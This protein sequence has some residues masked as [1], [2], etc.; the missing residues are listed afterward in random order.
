MAPQ[1]HSLRLRL[2]R[3]QG[4]ASMKHPLPSD[5]EFPKAATVR[6]LCRHKRWLSHTTNADPTRPEYPPVAVPALVH[7]AGTAPS[8]LATTAGRCASHVCTPRAVFGPPKLQHQPHP[9]LNAA[10]YAP[11]GLHAL[12]TYVPCLIKRKHM[13]ACSNMLMFRFCSIAS[14]DSTTNS[15]L[16]PG[17]RSPRS[18][19]SPGQGRRQQTTK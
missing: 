17:R 3:K 16:H 4:P 10:R 13:R 14:K 12:D 7:N 15:P 6:S 19:R 18:H 5:Y 8:T 2:Q 11:A 1:T 9:W